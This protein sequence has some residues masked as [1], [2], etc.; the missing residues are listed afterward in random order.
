MV[1]LYLIYSIGRFVSNVVRTDLWDMHA[2]FVLREAAIK[3]YPIKTSSMIGLPT[4]WYSCSWVTFVSKTCSCLIANFNT[5]LRSFYEWNIRVAI[6][7]LQNY[8]EISQIWNTPEYPQTFSCLLSKTSPRSN[9]TVESVDSIRP[10]RVPT[11]KA[12]GYLGKW[13]FQEATCRTTI[14]WA[15]FHAI[16]ICFSMK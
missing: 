3:Q 15:D 5:V 14:R 12:S 16:T 4:S 13:N 8:F 7:Q 1:P 6:E 9:V 11:R 10:L 2:G